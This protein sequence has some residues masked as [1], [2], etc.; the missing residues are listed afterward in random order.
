MHQLN[1]IKKHKLWSTNYEKH[2]TKQAAF[3]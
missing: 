1:T 2:R 3:V